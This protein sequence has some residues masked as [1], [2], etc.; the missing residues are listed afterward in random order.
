MDWAAVG[1]Q[2][3]LAY[4][5]SLTFYQLGLLFTGKGFGFG[6]LVALV[7]LAGFLYLLFRPYKDLSSSNIDKVENISA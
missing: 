5:V 7:L 6:T 3:G 1:Y 2:T 4:F